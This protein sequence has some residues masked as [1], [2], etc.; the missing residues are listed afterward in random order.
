L[1]LDA[2]GRI[3]ES[4]STAREIVGLEADELHQS[5]LFELLGTDRVSLESLA[6]SLEDPLQCVGDADC[7][8]VV[9][10]TEP[11]R[12]WYAIVTDLSGV[13][14]A[15]AE[16]VRREAR[17]ESRMLISGFA[18]EVRNPIAAILSMTEA[19]L[20]STKSSDFGKEMVEPVPGLIRR[21]EAVISDSVNYSRPNEP[22]PVRVDAEQVVEEVLVDDPPPDDVEVVVRDVARAPFVRVDPWQTR[23]IIRALINNAYESGADRIRIEI[24]AFPAHG[25]RLGASIKVIDDGSGVEE[26]HRDSIFRPFFTTRAEKT[27][28]GLATA[29]TLARLNRGSLQFLGSKDGETCF[30]LLLPENADANLTEVHRD[31]W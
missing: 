7:R 11:E 17:E 23:R 29:R 9:C 30:E 19:V 15:L 27:G 13:R 24:D 4:D 10:R 21:I 14:E 28:L 22:V 16:A 20:Q 2:D 1:K 31:V 26:K 5:T 18:H 6:E 25:T 12:D 3:V 8:I